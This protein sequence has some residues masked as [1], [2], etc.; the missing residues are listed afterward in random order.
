MTD[1]KKKTRTPRRTEQSEENT[2][3]P[4]NVQDENVG[5]ERNGVPLREIKTFGEFSGA[6]GLNYE[7]LVPRLRLGRDVWTA[8]EIVAVETVREQLVQVA[9][10]GR[11]GRREEEDFAKNGILR[12]KY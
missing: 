2:S 12:I 8:A 10:Q 5:V 11:D 3:S 4:G 9:W 7:L 6:D 1:I